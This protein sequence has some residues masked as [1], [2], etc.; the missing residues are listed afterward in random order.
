M[1][2]LFTDFVQPDLDL[3]KR[4]LSEA[5]HEAVVAAPP[6]RTPEALTQAAQ[7]VEALVVQ[8]APITRAVFE[9]LPALKIVSVPQ[10][11]VD[12]IDLDAARDRGVW[13]ANVPTGNV[14]EV[15]AHALAMALALLR[16]LPAFDRSVRAGTWD[17]EA[18]GPLRRPGEL[19][20]GLLGLGHIGLLVAERAAPVFG[21]VMA[22]DPY[23][24][25][26]AWPA[27]VARAD[28]MTGL[29]AESD[30]VSLHLPL[31]EESR[32]LVGRELLAAMR[33]GSFLVNVSRGPIVDIAGVIDALD[34]GRLAGAALDV[35]PQEPPDPSDPILR[36]PKVLLSPHA[37]FYSL[38][39]DEELRRTCIENIVALPRDGR[40]RYVVVEGR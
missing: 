22:Y 2:V 8:E 33:P 39:A 34:S 29:F 11:G 28:A 12:S 19:T 30:L 3:E 6:C 35:L 31:T 14:T 16:Q 24:D 38:E 26:A 5:G 36:H 23:R 21:R 15:A 27:A 40:P 18:A 10:I 25:S 37:A 13:V 20:L 7:G 32:G 4:L 9:A 1:K 17:Y